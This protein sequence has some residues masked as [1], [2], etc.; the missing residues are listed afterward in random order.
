MKH[1]LFFIIIATVFSAC[2][3]T[4]RQHPNPP[5][6]P[7][8]WSDVKVKA[9][10]QGLVLDENKK[11]VAN[12]P[13]RSGTYITYTNPKGYFF[14]DNIQIN[15]IAGTVTV[16][17][18]S[19]FKATRTLMVKEGSVNFVT[20]QLITQ[21][22]SGTF[23]SGTGGLVNIKQG[24]SVKFDANSVVSAS[25]N[26]PYSGEVYLIG[27]YINP[28]DPEISSIMPGN[29]MGLEQDNNLKQ[30]Q[31]FGMMA[32][33]M[34]GST[35]EKLEL[36]SGKT[37]TIS[38]PI[39]AS[40]VA[41]AP[42]TIPLWHFD[43]TTG[44]WKKEGTA[45][46]EGNSYVGKVSH[47]SFWNCDVPNEFVTLS[48]RFA[49]HGGY[50][51]P[52]YKVKLTNPL[53]GSFSFGTTNDNG[54]VEGGVPVN[55]KIL[56][57][58]F[59]FCGKKVAADQIGPFSSSADLGT[60][61]LEIPDLPLVSITGTAKNCKGDKLTNGFADVFLDERYYRAKVIDGNFSVSINRCNNTAATAYISVTDSDAGQEGNPVPLSVGSGTYNVESLA[62]CGFSVNEYIEVKLND[63]IH[64]TFAPP[65]DNIGIYFGQPEMGISAIRKDQPRPNFKVLFY[66]DHIPAICDLT[67][68]NFNNGD[69]LIRATGGT[70]SLVESG[71]RH[72]FISG[73]IK[74]RL[75]DLAYKNF[76]EADIK[77]KVKRN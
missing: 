24:S 45:T 15:K 62:G 28:T 26:I 72:D 59:D 8:P 11:P 77:F 64:Y 68:I 37:A 74:V 51:M 2:K 21:I 6:A 20:I 10:I 23:Q 14:F 9:S 22:L 34:R 25:G 63:S 52:F 43:D 58:M 67:D 18:P 73:E 49:T 71:P 65:A 7:Q 47:F 39:P 36:S 42:A 31:T 38:M 30:L 33:E 27:A 75:R 12:A 56:R 76:Y 19:H 16:D 35:G 61:L 60:T 50:A 17:L 48:M 1:L 3:K 29:L 55:A 44:L 32:I 70:V 54:V 5:V 41:T 66:T 40:L 13:V 46:K 53:D 69:S 4:D 57:E